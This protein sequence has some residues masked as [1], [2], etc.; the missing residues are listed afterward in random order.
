MLI[1][2]PAL[3]DSSLSNLSLTRSWSL[4][5]AHT[6][7]SSLEIDFILTLGLLFQWLFLAPASGLTD[8]VL[9][10]PSMFSYYQWHFLIMNL[11]KAK[12]LHNFFQLILRIN[13]V[14]RHWILKASEPL[15]PRSEVCGRRSQ[16]A[17]RKWAYPSPFGADKLDSTTL[18]TF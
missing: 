2:L 16:K 4:V 15:T 10:F 5:D 6:Y 3:C 18:H 12:F 13:G 17:D 9:I 1:V 11:Y 7:Q 8:N 14:L